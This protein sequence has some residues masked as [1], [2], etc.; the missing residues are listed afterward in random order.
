MTN[1]G[2]VVGAITMIIGIGLIGTFTGYLANAFLGPRP[3]VSPSDPDDPR[4]QP[5]IVR[6]EL[7]E[8]ARAAAEL[9]ARL[10]KIVSV[11]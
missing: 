5:E 6:R 11:L 4:A 8:N 1:P 10:Q 3:A 7:D 9:Q 2:R